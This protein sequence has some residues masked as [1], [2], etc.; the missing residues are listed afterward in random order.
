MATAWKE[1]IKRL[2]SG[3]GW[4]DGSDA[5]LCCIVVQSFLKTPNATVQGVIA[6]SSVAFHQ[7]KVLESLVIENYA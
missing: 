5:T 2:Q 6:C 3:Q 7:L 4:N 1:S